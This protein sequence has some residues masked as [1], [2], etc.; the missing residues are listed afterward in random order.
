MKRNRLFLLMSKLNSR[1]LKRLEEMVYSPF[2]I[3]DKKCRKLFELLKEYAPLYKLTSEDEHKIAQEVSPGKQWN[4]ASLSFLRSKLLHLIN[5][6]LVYQELQERKSYK[7]HLLIKSLLKR[8]TNTYALSIYNQ[9]KKLNKGQVKKD[10]D[11]YYDQYLLE[12]NYVNYLRL[13]HGRDSKQQIINLIK[14]LDNYYVARKLNL[15]GA[16]LSL[17]AVVGLEYDDIMLSN[18]E[19]LILHPQFRDNSFIKLYYY[20]FQFL[21]NEENE[22]AFHNLIELLDSPITKSFLKEDIDIFYTHAANYCAQRMRSGRTEFIHHLFDIQLAQIEHKLIYEGKFILPNRMKNII[23][24][25]CQLGKM[26]WAQEFLDHYKED[27]NPKIKDSA[28][29]MFNAFICF[30]NKD[31]EGTILQ[32]AQMQKDIDILYFLNT[33]TFQLRCYYELSSREAFYNLRST[34]LDYLRRTK[35]IP[36]AKKKS[37]SNFTR[38][39]YILYR[40]KEGFS[41][42]PVSDIRE[43]IQ[44]TS[45]LELKGW[46]LEKCNELKP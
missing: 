19:D 22:T 34:F 29:K 3:K 6:L 14:N 1:E 28:T 44:S 4:D 2:F 43:K 39:A 42:K 33:R 27:L 45:P 15:S 9:T 35:K 20:I 16:L 10:V 21:K 41:K 30:Y 32:L 12:E 23:S 40:K 18:I 7:S 37:H 36:S 38:L 24:I 46:L 13:E 25:A 8:R 26:S 11:H 31:F 5:E 17:R